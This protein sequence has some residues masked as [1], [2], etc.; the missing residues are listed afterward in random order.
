MA[1]DL[2]YDPARSALPRDFDTAGLDG[3]KR[4][5]ALLDPRP[6]TIFGEDN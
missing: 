6:D 2:Y 3:T 1:C 4:A 5:L